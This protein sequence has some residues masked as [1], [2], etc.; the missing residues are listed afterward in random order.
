MLTRFLFNPTQMMRFEVCTYHCRLSRPPVPYDEAG[1]V[2]PEERANDIVN[3]L[4]ER[5]ADL[6]R[7][8]RLELREASFRMRLIGA[9]SPQVD[10]QARMNKA[11]SVSRPRGQIRRIIVI[12]G[13]SGE[14]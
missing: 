9:D 6:E 5:I 13:L 4:Y 7:D 11:V 10:S 8:R 12:V 2:N 3:D 1:S 14:R